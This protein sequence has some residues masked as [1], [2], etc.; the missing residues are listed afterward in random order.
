[1]PAQSIL[2]IDPFKNLVNAYRIILEGEGYGVESAFNLEEAS[3]SIVQ[4]KPSVIIM[5]YIY[6]YE[7]TEEFIEKV[8]RSSPELYILMVANALIDGEA[9]E[10]LLEKGVDDLILK[11]YSPDRIL[12]LIKKGLRKREMIL[13]LK[14]LDR[15]YPFHPITHQINEYIFNRSF[16]Q[17]TV[18]QELK[19]AKRHQHPI[20][21]ILIKIPDGWKENDEVERCL[22]ELLSLIRKHTRS[23]DVLSRHNGEITLLL[24]ETNQ[25]GCQALSKRLHQLIEKDLA[26][27]AEA[28]LRQFGKS[29]LFQTVDLPDRLDL[30]EMP[31]S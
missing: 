17:R 15:F 8:K 21:L 2:L 4:K 10:R 23:E 28:S 25:S 31:H 20:S 7:T 3:A 5:E 12:V 19:R 16:F 1:M 30:L 11:P 22:K 27:Q 9:F 18:Q 13:H 26:F 6:P 24:P 29:I 14:E